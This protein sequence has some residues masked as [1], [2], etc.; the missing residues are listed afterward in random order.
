M[1]TDALQLTGGKAD[2]DVRRAGVEVEKA[3]EDMWKR[4]PR[5]AVND[6]PPAMHLGLTQRYFKTGRAPGRLG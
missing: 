2:I 1:A 3:L 5:S 6:L 4:Y